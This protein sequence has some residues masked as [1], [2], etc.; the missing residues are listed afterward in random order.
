[1]TVFFF[2]LVINFLGI[3]ESSDASN[4]RFTLLLA[5][6]GSL[7]KVGLDFSS[8]SAQESVAN[9]DQFQLHIFFSPVAGHHLDES[10]Q[11]ESYSG[12]TMA[13]ECT[14]PQSNCSYWK[15]ADPEGDL[16]DG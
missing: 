15:R 7:P 6:S 2:L 4:H 8:F 14:Y 13:G 3:S 10:T 16:S 11:K 12:M 9:L 1:M 5:V